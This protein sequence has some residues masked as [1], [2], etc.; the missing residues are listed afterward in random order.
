MQGQENKTRNVNYH[1]NVNK[2]ANQNFLHMELSYERMPV[3]QH[4][5]FAVQ[6]PMQI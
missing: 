5:K 3:I 4:I 6:V 2:N 1:Q